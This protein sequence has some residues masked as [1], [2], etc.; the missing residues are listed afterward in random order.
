M[1]LSDEHLLTTPTMS[2]KGRLRA[3]QIVKTS[4][5]TGEGLDGRPS[6][7]L[8]MHLAIYRTRPDVNAIVHAHS[9][10]AVGLT[11]AGHSLARPAVPE[12]IQLLGS[13]PTVPYASPTTSDVADA[14]AP[15]AA[16]HDAFIL[17]R[18]GTVA[19]GS[20]LDQAMSRVEIVEHTAKIT[21]I[22]MS[23]GRATPIPEAEAERLRAM[24]VA[25]GLLRPR[26][27]GGELG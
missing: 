20:D 5:Q 21:A 27:N 6:S 3:E 13:V 7:E 25:A 8:K 26:P 22:A 4:S 2:H 17:E 23:V 12:A 24:S 10:Y 18:H 14:V 9:P 1:R 15:I 11:V 19:L 16:H